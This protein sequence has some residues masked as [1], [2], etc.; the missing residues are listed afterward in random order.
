[1]IAQIIY[2]KDSIQEREAGDMAERLA[3][4]RVTAKLVEADSA[5][6]IATCQLYDLTG[7]PAVVLA[8]DDGTMVERWQNAWPTI[9]EVSYLAHQ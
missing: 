6:G 8:R 3:K 9:A 1:M 5:E 2:T 7:R 4:L